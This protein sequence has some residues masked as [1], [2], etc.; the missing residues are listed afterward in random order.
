ME[1]RPGMNILATKIVEAP[2][3]EMARDNVVTGAR[4]EETPAAPGFAKVA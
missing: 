2:R 3:T 1:L 4:A